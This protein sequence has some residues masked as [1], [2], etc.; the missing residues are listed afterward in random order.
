MFWPSDS[1]DRVSLSL[2]VILEKIFFTWGVKMEK[3]QFCAKKIRR[4]F[5]F[6]GN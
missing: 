6:R 5:I 3:S 2:K 1:E 4:R